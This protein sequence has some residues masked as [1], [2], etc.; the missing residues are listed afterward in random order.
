MTKSSNNGGA[1]VYTLGDRSLYHLLE[2]QDDGLHELPDEREFARLEETSNRKRLSRIGQ[3][4]GSL[5]R[6][7]RRHAYQPT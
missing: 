1:D 2:E 5:M 4:L 6:K 3:R 7:R